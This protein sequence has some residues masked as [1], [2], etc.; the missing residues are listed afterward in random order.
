MNQL[1]QQLLNDLKA[2]PGKALLLGAL[3]LVGLYFWVPGAIKLAGKAFSGRAEA[4]ATAQSD[5]KTPSAEMLVPD[6]PAAVSADANTVSQ[7]LMRTAEAD[8][9]SRD[10]FQLD[11]DQFPPPVLFAEAELKDYGPSRVTSFKPPAVDTEAEDM[12]VAETPEPEQPPQV[13][14]YGLEL[15]STVISTTRRAAMINTK[16]YYE[17]QP[18]PSTAGSV[19][20]ETVQPKRVV[21]RDGNRK[22]ELTIKRWNDQE[23]TDN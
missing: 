15:K 7:A 1:S 16:L 9:F 20:L 22:I 8:E 19:L 10:P 2:S 12:A 17:G 11:H 23:P 6:H 13:A 18:V 5:V 4:V 3:L 21:L 14:D